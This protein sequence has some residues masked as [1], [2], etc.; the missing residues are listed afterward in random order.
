M[1]TA[2]DL[3]VVMGK[4]YLTDFSNNLYSVNAKNGAVSLIGPPECRPTRTFPSP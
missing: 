3:A 4:V 2:F 1:S